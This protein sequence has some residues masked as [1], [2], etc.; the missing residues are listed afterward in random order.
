MSG[1]RNLKLTQTTVQLT[2]CVDAETKE[3]IKSK[4]KKV[5]DYI[6]DIPWNDDA[7]RRLE[8][9]QQMEILLHDP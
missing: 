6:V 2:V 8:N 9:P 3:L 7:E 4:H 5:F 1:R